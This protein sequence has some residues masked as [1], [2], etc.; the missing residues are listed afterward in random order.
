MHA[1]PRELDAFVLGEHLRQ[2]LM[3]EPC[4]RTGGQFHHP[5]RQRLIERVGRPPTAV[6][7]RERCCP[8]SR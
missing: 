8:R 4:V 5:Q 2:V 6:A 7:V 3:V 1:G